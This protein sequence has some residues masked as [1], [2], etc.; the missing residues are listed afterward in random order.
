MIARTIRPIFSS[1]PVFNVAA[2]LLIAFILLAKNPYLY[3]YPPLYD[4]LLLLRHHVNNPGN[5]FYFYN[6]YFSLLPNVMA[7]LSIVLFPLNWIPRIF[8]IESLLICTVTIWL[9]CLNC[10]AFLVSNRNARLTIAALIA[11][12]PIGNWPLQVQLMFQMWNLAIISVLFLVVEQRIDNLKWLFM[13]LIILIFTWS[14]PVSV[15][16]LP[17]FVLGGIKS[18]HKKNMVRLGSYLVLCISVLIYVYK[19]IKLKAV[20]TINEFYYIATSSLVNVFERILID[21]FFPPKLRIIVREESQLIPIAIAIFIFIFLCFLVLKGTRVNRNIRRLSILTGYI[22]LTVTIFSIASRFRPKVPWYLLEQKFRYFYLQ[23]YCMLLLFLISAYLLINHMKKHVKTILV[24][25][26][27]VL[28]ITFAVIENYRYHYK[29]IPDEFLNSF[30]LPL[31]FKWQSLYDQGVKVVACLDHAQD[32]AVA[33][34]DFVCDEQ[35]LFGDE[36]FRLHFDS[37][38]Q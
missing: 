6:G 9:F 12:Q 4:D 20:P 29:E 36:P 16:F 14:N 33:Q 26:A 32:S 5:L 19:G 18:F 25:M 10:Y 37:K 34:R 1:A 8:A 22:C 11:I 2:F 3:V 13:T 35:V 31:S 24:L 21:S 23:Q 27:F 7:K 15:C 30:S 17:F 38:S 28:V